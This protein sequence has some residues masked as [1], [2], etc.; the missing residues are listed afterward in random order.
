MSSFSNTLLPPILRLG[1]TADPIV[2]VPRNTATVATRVALVRPLIERAPNPSGVVIDV[3][4]PV[5][6]GR[7][8]RAR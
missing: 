3:K 2:T 7:A 1:D 5:V 6:R 8:K 4:R